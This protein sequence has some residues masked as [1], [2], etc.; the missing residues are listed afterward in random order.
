MKGKFACFV[1]LC[2]VLMY[3]SAGFGQAKHEA[4]ITVQ[5]PFQ[6]DVGNQTLPA[7][8]YKIQSLLQSVPGKANIDVLMVRRVEGKSYAAV[9]AN[10]VGNDA[11][12]DAKLVFMRSEGH[13]YLSEVWDSKKQVGYRLQRAQASVQTAEN[14]SQKVTLVASID[15]P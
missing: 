6:F 8:T 2:G 4:C 13:A 9:V 7:G 10:V 1:F 11:P 3:P 12:Q 14:D 15:L 5:V